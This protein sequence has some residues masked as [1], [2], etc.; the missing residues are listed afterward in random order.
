MSSRLTG[1]VRQAMLARQSLSSGLAWTAAAV[2]LPTALRLAI[3]GERS[4]FPFVTYFPAIALAAL[5]LGWRYG[6]LVALLSAVAAWLLFMHGEPPLIETPEGAA[7]LA[8]SVL[9]CVLLIFI[10][11]TLRQTF[12]EL[13]EVSTREE[14]LN[15]ELRHRMKNMLAVVGSLSSL[16]HRHADPEKA[17]IAFAERL[18]ALDRATSLLGGDSTVACALPDLAE[19]ALRP[20]QSDYDIRLSGAPQQVHRDCCVP[21]V[22]ALHELATN[23]IK[24]GALSVPH[25]WVELEWGEREGGMVTLRWREYGGPPVVKPERR[26]LGS[27]ILSMHSAATS[28][29]IDF[30]PDGVRCEMQ[31]KAT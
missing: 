23:A 24:Y 5:F 30:A 9:S 31:L 19:E 20:F 28:F 22:L 18:A 4:G 1:R 2:V 8:L 17:H 12:I 25:G 16:T 14:L 13:E 7:I 6:A 15:A 11:E 27:R 3:D 26:G 10:G 21:A 29:K